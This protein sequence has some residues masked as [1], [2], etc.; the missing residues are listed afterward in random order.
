MTQSFKDKILEEAISWIESGQQVALATGAIGRG[1]THSSNHQSRGPENADLRG[2]YRS[3]RART[4][5][6]EQP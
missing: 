5:T 3:E 6:E 2:G 1:A 4:D